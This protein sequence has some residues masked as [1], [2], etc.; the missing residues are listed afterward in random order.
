VARRI[1]HDAAVPFLHVNTANAAAAH[2][3]EKM[4]FRTRRLMQVAV[5]RA[6]Q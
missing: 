5:L 1:V 2:V 6:P 3:Y 4:G